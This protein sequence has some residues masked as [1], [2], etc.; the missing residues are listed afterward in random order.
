MPLTPPECDLTDFR[1]MPLEIARLRKSKGWLMAKR[2]PALGFYMLNLWMAS[3]HEVPAASLEDDDDVLADVAGCD[4]KKWQSVKEKVMRGWVKCSDGRLYHPVVAEKALE[5]YERKKAMRQ[6]TEAARAARMSSRQKQSPA[7]SGDVTVSVTDNAT[8][9]ATDN[10]TISVTDNVTGLPLH[11]R[12]RDRD[13]DSTKRKKETPQPPLPGGPPPDPHNCIE[14]GTGREIV[15][16]HYWRPVWGLVCD[17]ARI[18][19]EREN[20]DAAPV[21][22]WL[23]AGIPPDDF[24]P[25]LRKCA[26]RAGYEPP[27]TLAY[28]DRAVMEKRR[29]TAS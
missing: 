1:F 5:S 6:R 2:D 21:R 17:A 24:L 29:E 10:V 4:M 15:G 28:F 8:H 7:T 14:D 27:R 18:G 9:D 20:S 23:Q 16:G 3:W 25:V 11:P 26:A 19:E 12:D 22:R 13:R